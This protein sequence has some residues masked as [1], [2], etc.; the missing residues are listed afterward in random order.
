MIK[1]LFY[2]FIKAVLIDYHQFYLKNR[3]LYTNSAPEFM[4]GL[5]IKSIKDEKKRS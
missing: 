1:E 5:Y 3:Q 4:V 2:K